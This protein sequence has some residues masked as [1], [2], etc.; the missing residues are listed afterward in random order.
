MF[1]TTAMYN[2]ITGLV[3]DQT[4]KITMRAIFQNHIS[5]HTTRAAVKYFKDVRVCTYL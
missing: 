5:F 3:T 1:N 4:K 2:T